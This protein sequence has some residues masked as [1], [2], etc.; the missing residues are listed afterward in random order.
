MA[1]FVR[2]GKTNGAATA[3]TTSWTRLVALWIKS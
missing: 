2:K 3:L 1:N